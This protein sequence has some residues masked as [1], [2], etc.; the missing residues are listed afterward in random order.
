M[1]AQNALNTRLSNKTYPGKENIFFRKLLLIVLACFLFCWAPMILNRVVEM[2]LPDGRF[3]PPVALYTGTTV[4]AMAN[5]AMNPVL[6]ALFNRNF[7][8]AFRNI[9]RKC[10]NNQVV[11]LP[12][13]F[14]V[15]TPD[16][17]SPFRPRPL[18]RTLASL[19]PGSKN[20]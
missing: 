17:T 12:E 18:R 1:F 19:M 9:Y 8:T 11:P 10:F 4:L 2:V 7:R 3:D 16:A 5:S 20:K 6:Y 14:S 15:A 13:A